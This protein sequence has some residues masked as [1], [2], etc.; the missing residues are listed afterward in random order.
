MTTIVV[1]IILRKIIMIINLLSIINSLVL[2]IHSNHYSFTI[3][4]RKILINEANFI[5]LKKQLYRRQ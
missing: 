5:K 1:I 2:S 3:I 4:N